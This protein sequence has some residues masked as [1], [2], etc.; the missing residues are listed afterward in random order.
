MILYKNL[1]IVSFSVCC[2]F[3]SIVANVARQNVCHA[4][5]RTRLIFSKWCGLITFL[6]KKRNKT[7]A[8]SE[9]INRV[10]KVVRIGLIYEECIKGILLNPYN[11]SY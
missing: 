7:W 10:N 8:K 6:L 11:S 3:C 4:C 2:I 5:A 1:Y 9:K